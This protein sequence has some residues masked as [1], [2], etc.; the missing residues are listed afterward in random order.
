[1]KRKELAQALARRQRIPGAI[2]QDRV[3]AVVHDILQKLKSGTP[4][5]LPGLGKLIVAPAIKPTQ[6]RQRRAQ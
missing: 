2:A 1:M 5:E 3:D 4:A 6:S